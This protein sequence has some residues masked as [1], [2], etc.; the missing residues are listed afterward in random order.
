MGARSRNVEY[1]EQ[2]KSY[3]AAV[4]LSSAGSGVMKER[5]VL[6]YVSYGARRFFN[7]SSEKN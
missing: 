3:A 1:T 7:R 2:T 6:Q 5:Y 4:A